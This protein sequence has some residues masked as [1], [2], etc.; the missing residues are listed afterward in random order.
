MEDS[1][2]AVLQA[3]NRRPASRNLLDSAFPIG[4]PTRSRW[5]EMVLARVAELRAIGE[6]ARIESE[7]PPTSADALVTAIS[8]HLEA[9]REAALGATRVRD[10]RT[11]EARVERAAANLDLAEGNILRLAPLAWVR[12]QLPTILTAVRGYLPPDDP[13]RLAV[14]EM[15]SADGRQIPD[16]VAREQVVAAALAA[17]GQRREE[18]V[19]IRKLRNILTV[20]L[21]LLTLAAVG[22][23]MVGA[24]RPGLLPLCFPADE[25][26][27][28]PSDQVALPQ[29]D[30]PQTGEFLSSAPL[31]ERDQFARE[32]ADPWDIALVEI[33]GVIA[34]SVAAAT[35]LRGFR[36]RPSPYD[37]PLLL[38]LLKLPAGAV[39]AVLGLL[40]IRAEF[41]PGLST[42]DSAT[43]IVAWAI[44]FGYSQQIFT[45]FV[46]QRT[47]AV[48][49]EVEGV[50]EVPRPREP[51]SRL[52]DS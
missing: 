21:L 26:V 32:A 38:T 46:D 25:T 31:A 4:G 43:Q 20:P 51:G 22:F 24:T 42:I 2:P 18:L 1:S 16:E 27:S 37:F 15:Q 6:R 50:T 5:R 17:H 9:A 36:R 52:A 47:E 10:S 44:V 29:R 30:Q 40:L 49:D 3:N 14:E 13:R 12:A 33:I 19:Q 35:A 34:A 8:G 28:C 23:L 11:N 45:R 39:T 48:L 7:H 41:V